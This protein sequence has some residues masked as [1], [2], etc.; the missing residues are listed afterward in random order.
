[1]RITVRLNGTATNPYHRMGLTRNPFPQI[2]LAEYD[3][4][5]RA[6]AAL[7]ADPIPDTDHIR[8]VLAGFSPEF[9]DVCCL[10]YRPGEMVVF[11]VTFPE[12]RP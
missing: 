5:E 4:A 9:V 6:L 11:A 3:A 2:G 1:M 8:R 10:K 12:A 7:A